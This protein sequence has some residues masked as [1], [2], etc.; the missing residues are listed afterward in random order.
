MHDPLKTWNRYAEG[1]MLTWL[2]MASAPLFLSTF[3][4][5]EGCGI[6]AI[7]LTS[8]LRDIYHACRDQQFEFPKADKDLLQ[9]PWLSKCHVSKLVQFDN[10]STLRK[11]C[12]NERILC[13]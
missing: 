3:R 12:S 6:T 1:L 2:F 11:A 13:L 10:V 5:P 9:D 8:F 7:D 4:P